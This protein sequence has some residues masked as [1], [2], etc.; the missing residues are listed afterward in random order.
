[1]ELLR[2]HLWYRYL[3]VATFRFVINNPLLIINILLFMINI[4]IVTDA[5]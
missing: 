3:L 2:K 4:V 1:M 5:R